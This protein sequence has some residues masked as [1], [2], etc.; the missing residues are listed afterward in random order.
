ME[1]RQ[2]VAALPR[3]ILDGNMNMVLGTADEV[4]R[5][6]VSPVYCA[7]AGQGSSSV[8][9]CGEALTQLP[10]RAQVSIAVFNSQVPILYRATATDH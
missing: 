6:R 5:S 8:V 1:P 9:S 2:D 10:T 3:T 4:G 7:S